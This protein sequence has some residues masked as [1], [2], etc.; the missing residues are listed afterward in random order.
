MAIL[1]EPS[2][3]SPQESYHANVPTVVP[4]LIVSSGSLVATVYAIVT[5]EHGRGVVPWYLEHRHIKGAS[6]RKR[7]KISVNDNHGEI[8][9]ITDRDH[10]AQDDRAMFSRNSGFS[11]TGGQFNNVSGDQVNIQASASSE[12]YVLSVPQ[13]IPTIQGES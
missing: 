12:V 6:T 8:D 10:D 3:S 4:I 2:S 7:R 1:E 5:F 11:I 13:S 9:Y